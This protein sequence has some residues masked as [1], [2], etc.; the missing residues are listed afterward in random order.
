MGHRLFK[1][2]A[3]HSFKHRSAGISTVPDEMP[4]KNKIASKDDDAEES[5]HNGCAHKGSCKKKSIE[6]ETQGR[7]KRN[8]GKTREMTKSRKSLLGLN[9]RAILKHLTV[10]LS[11]K[12]LFASDREARRSIAIPFLQS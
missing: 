3:P 8:P 4:H 5:R 9:L 10:G 1:L 6:K 12:Q 11:H 2:E 7:M